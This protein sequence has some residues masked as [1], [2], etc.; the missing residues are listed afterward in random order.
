L[1]SL[2][3]RSVVSNAFVAA[4]VAAEADHGAREGKAGERG[5]E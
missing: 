5:S 4:H 3:T 1:S 2:V